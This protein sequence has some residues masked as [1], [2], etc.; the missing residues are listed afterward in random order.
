MKPEH[1]HNLKINALSDNGTEEDF[2]MMYEFYRPKLVVIVKSYIPS[3]EDAEEIVHDVF[4]KLWE[5]WETL[6]INSNFTGYIYSMTR[7]ACL[8]YLRT[9]KNK[10]TKDL[11]AEQQEFWLNHGALADDMASS[12]LAKELQA[13][14]DGAIDELPEKCKKVFKKSRMEGLCHRE[15]SKEMEISP[16][17]VENHIARALRQ[18]RAALGE[19]LPTLFF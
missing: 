3:R 4:I 19:Y 14:V 12:I 16:K 13:L 7:N 6:Q 18:L 15:I 2:S 11:S 9:R 1:L 10:L 5:K 17:T 8:D